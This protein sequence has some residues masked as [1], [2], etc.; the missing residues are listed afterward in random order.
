MKARHQRMAFIGAVV[1]AMAVAAGFAYRA[2]QENML[3]YYS[4]TQVVDGEAP[5]DRRFRLGGLVVEGSV[6]QVPG[7]LTMF[8]EVTDRAHTIPVRY[9]RIPPNLF[10]EGK[11]VVAHGTLDT[12]GLFVADDVLAK[13][14]ENYM[15]PEVAESLADA[16]GN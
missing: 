7:E 10:Q 15:A 1:A 9:D 6:D 11:G 12:D 14:D 5:L 2:L 3:Y 8:F 4:P 13:H 16:G